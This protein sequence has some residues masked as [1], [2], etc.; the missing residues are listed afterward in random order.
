MPRAPFLGRR[1]TPSFPEEVTLHTTETFHVEEIRGD[2]L[3]PPIAAAGRLVCLVGRQ[4]GQTFGLGTRS[5]TIGRDA[6]VDIRVE[7]HD[8]SRRHAAI[9]WHDGHYQLRDLGSRNGTTINSIPVRTAVL[10]IGDRIQLGATALLV[11]AHDDELERR[12]ARLQKLESLAHLAGG[13]VHDFKNT[14]GVILAN[15]DIVSAI[16]RARADEDP[17]LLACLADVQTATR[18][19]T[20]LAQRLLFF[21]RRDVAAPT[22]PVNLA[23]L[24]AEVRAM[25]RH[26]FDR[27]PGIR[28]TVD[29]AAD[30]QVRGQPGELQHALLNLCLN[31][32]DAMPN[33]GE[34][35]IAARAIVLAQVEAL[36]LHLPAPGPFVELQV[37]DDGIGMDAATLAHVFE[38]FFTTKRPGE[39]TGLGLSTVYGVVRSHGGNVLVESVRGKG[40]CFR[41]LLPALAAT[42]LP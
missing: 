23:R 20:E 21:A 26:S 18:S 25:I 41:I 2:T 28:I 29:V 11:Y 12:A 40:T 9:E 35:S 38:P 17:D 10:Q 13:M 5:L 22:S 1:V 36:E 14:L 6:D 34:L 42:A 32:R 27:R 8:V 3:A 4:A 19:G 33:G 37:T 15:V 30:L 24:V 7:G 31:A 39:G 16:L